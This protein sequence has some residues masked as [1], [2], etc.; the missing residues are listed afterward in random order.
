M[1]RLKQR[2]VEKEAK[3]RLDLIESEKK[4]RLQGQ[5]MLIAKEKSL[6]AF[7]ALCIVE[8]F[9]GVGSWK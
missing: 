6:F 5:E 4:R 2:R 3:E 8:Y 1:E 9:A 7:S